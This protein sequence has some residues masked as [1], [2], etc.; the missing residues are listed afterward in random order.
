MASTTVL[1]L[2]A[3]A[4]PATA[5]RDVPKGECYD[6]EVTCFEDCSLKYDREIM[7]ADLLQV[8][9][10]NR[11]E[12]LTEQYSQCLQEDQCPCNAAGKMALV[13]GGKKKGKCAAGA[14]PCSAECGQKVIEKDQAS[15]S[16]K[17]ALLQKDFPLHSVKI[18]AFSKGAMTLDHCL[19]Y[20]LAATCGCEDAAGMNAA[21]A[22]KYGEK[23]L[24]NNGVTDTPPSAQYRY[25]KI[26][27][28]GKGMLGK[29]VASGLYIKLVGGPGGMFEVCSKE[30][31][32]KLLGP[33]GDIDGITAKCK[34]A[35]SDDAQYGCLWD[36]DKQNCHVGFSPILRCNTQYFNDKTL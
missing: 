12:S 9:K 14:A 25:A 28:C 36:N 5:L 33:S 3:L 13:A 27:E 16:K 7:Q 15:S 24:V 23:N 21:D 32:S 31:L 2:A 26:E 8:A 30:F 20:C 17:A 29:K 10:A 6:C 19:K 4:L 34:S 18:N 1:L 22:A 35:A 11:T